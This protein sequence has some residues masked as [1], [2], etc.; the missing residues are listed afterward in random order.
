MTDKRKIRRLLF[1]F[2][3]VRLAS[4]TMK[5]AS[6]PL[7]VGYLAAVTR[8]RTEVEVMDA[9]AESEHRHFMGDDFTWYGS[10][11]S[12]IRQRVERF[13]PDMVGM[14]CIFSS[15]FPVV[16]EVCRTVK[17]V[18][19]DIMTITGGT[20]P[21]FMPEYCLAELALDM[22]ALGEGETVITDLL[23]ALE[24]GTPLN[25]VDGLAFKQDG[26]VRVNPKNK[27]VEN[28]DQLPFPA[29]D[30][31]PTQVYKKSGIPH[32]LSISGRTFSPLITSR[33]CPANC[34]YCSSTRFWGNRYRFR[35]ANNVLDEIGEL[36]SRYGIEE[37]QFEDDNMTANK[38]R[39]MDIFQGI[40]DR[41]YN[42]RFNFPNGLA[43]WTLDEELI[44]LMAEA[45]CYEMTLAYESGSQKVL[46]EIVKKPTNLAKAESI[47]RYIRSRNIRTDAFYIIGFPG[48]TREQIRETFEFAR[49]MKTD[50]AYFFVANPLPGTEMYEMAKERGMLR[51]DFSFENLSYARSAYHQGVFPPGELEKMAARGFLKYTLRSF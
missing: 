16:R 51:S 30:L 45:G 48:E 9:V 17:S 22:I 21:T 2:P 15:V 43:L 6:F 42:V 37:V 12:E 3:P 1:L 25:E 27:W 7:G 28:L 38:K 24:A 49:R 4:D 26:K 14:T 41:G 19:P 44:D 46:S 10:P 34:V 13:R 31:M 32:S 20:Y 33:G 39:A 18:D 36:V 50:M 5:V 23:A 47:T 29:R 11:L 35:S 8:E 40:I